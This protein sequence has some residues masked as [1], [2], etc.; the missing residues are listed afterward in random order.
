M[1]LIKN[2]EIIGEYPILTKE[3]EIELSTKV[4]EGDLEA[5]K[6]FIY[7]NL[8][9]LL[10]LA[11]KYKKYGRLE[12]LVQE[13]CIGLI[14]AVDGFEPS[15]GYRFSGY[16]RFFIKKRIFLFLEGDKTIKFS[17]NVSR[18]KRRI[19]NILEE[20]VRKNGRE[21]SEDEILSKIKEK[22]LKFSHEYLTT[23][24]YFYKNE[25]IKSL[26][27]KISHH[28]DITLMD[29]ISE[30]NE[31]EIIEDIHNKLLIKKVYWAIEQLNNKRDGYIIKEKLL[32]QKNF[33][34]LG[35]RLGI[36]RTRVEQRYK[37]GIKNI[38][39]ILLENFTYE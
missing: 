12:D 7:S 38:K 33:S 23:S 5:R 1:D 11:I 31:N 25:K 17:Q 37:R 21:P 15:K 13:G 29:F 3:Q 28:G 10:N 24:L 22:K 35:K 34:Y 32:N 16:A 2:F 8:K 39:K 19:H 26:D 20:Y 30:N 4:K 27:A 14:E 18:L 6:K 36:S 9:L